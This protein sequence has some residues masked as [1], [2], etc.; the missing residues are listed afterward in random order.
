MLKVHFFS[1][2]NYNMFQNQVLV[3][4][5][6]QNP[7]KNINIKIRSQVQ[8]NDMVWLSTLAPKELWSK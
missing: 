7:T 1:L 3:T 2:I 5:N 8:Y 6:E 4:V